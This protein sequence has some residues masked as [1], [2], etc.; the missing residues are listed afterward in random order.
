MS[1]SQIASDFTFTLD[2]FFFCFGQPLPSSDEALALIHPIRNFGKLAYPKGICLGV[3]LSVTS[4]VLIA[5]FFVSEFLIQLVL[6]PFSFLFIGAS[7]K[8]GN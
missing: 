8:N 1:R 6:E 7:T 4:L 5:R 3:F 2:T